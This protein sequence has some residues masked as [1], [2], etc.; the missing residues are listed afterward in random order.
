MNGIVILKA[1]YLTFVMN[2]DPYFTIWF[3]QSSIACWTSMY[4]APNADYYVDG[5]M[6][7]KW[8]WLT[9]TAFSMMAFN[10]MESLGFDLLCPFI[11]P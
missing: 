1:N 11:Y 7:K 2:P 8:G 10:A 3:I 6:Q 5:V 4:F 9:L